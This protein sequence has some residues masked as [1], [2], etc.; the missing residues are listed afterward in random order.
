VAPTSCC[1][2]TA[3]ALVEG[4]ATVAEIFQCHAPSAL[5]AERLGLPASYV[6][7]YTIGVDAAYVAPPAAT[8]ADDGA[9]GLRDGMAGR[10]Y[11]T[12]HAASHLRQ[13]AMP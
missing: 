13:T 11:L 6:V 8:A 5:L 4:K 2:L 9:L 1:P 7:G 3:L 10:A 12:M